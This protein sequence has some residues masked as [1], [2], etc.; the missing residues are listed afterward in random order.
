MDIQISIDVE[1]AVRGALSPFF[2]IYC[3]PLPDK[4]T[5]PSL[6]V[7]VVGGSDTKQIDTFEIVLDARAKVEGDAYELLRKAI[8]AL[9]AIANDGNTP[10]RYVKVNSSGS[11]G[12]DP[13]RPDLAMASARLQIVAHLEQTQITQ[14]K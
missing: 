13:V 12:T 1:D 3:K 14:N 5:T 9:K 6:L 10:I 2:T 8:G 4:F 11:W 7:Q